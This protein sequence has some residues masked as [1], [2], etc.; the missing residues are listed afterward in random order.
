MYFL[1]WILKLNNFFERNIEENIEVI[2]SIS[3]TKIIISK[4]YSFHFISYMTRHILK[5]IEKQNIFSQSFRY[6][7]VIAQLGER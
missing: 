3:T 6:P 1:W 7:A 2:F 4:I 5:H